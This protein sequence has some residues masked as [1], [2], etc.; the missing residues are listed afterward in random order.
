MPE[1]A[2]EVARVFNT[3]REDC[4]AFAVRSHELALAAIAAGHFTNE[5]VPVTVK[6]RKGDTVVDTDE[7]PR[8][9]TTMEVLAGLRP[10]VK[11]GSV[12]TAGNAS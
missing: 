8:A 2:E 5:I 7:G 10:V 3:S 12:V 6:G 11:G 9:G 1:T 4:D